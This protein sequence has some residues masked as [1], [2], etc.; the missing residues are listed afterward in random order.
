M[1]V[2][3]ISGSSGEEETPVGGFTFLLGAVEFP[4]QRLHQ[5]SKASQHVTWV[6]S[7]ANGT[8]SLDAKS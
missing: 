7:R 3:G 4:E 1:A 8:K 5:A 2:K 6:G